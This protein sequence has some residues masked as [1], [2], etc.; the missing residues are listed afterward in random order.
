MALLPANPF[1][2]TPIG[3]RMH[4]GGHSDLPNWPTFLKFADKY[5]N[6]PTK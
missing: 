3:F 2:T 1:P 5:F 4:E 6:P